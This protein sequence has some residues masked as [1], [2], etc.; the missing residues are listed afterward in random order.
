MSDSLVISVRLHEGWY[1]GAG[2]IP[3]P[4]RIFQALIAGRGLSGP[5]PANSIAALEWLEQQPPPIVAAPV[6]KAG[7]PVATFVPN[8]DLD[9]KQG[10]H[11]RIGEIRTKKSIRPLLFDA[12]VPFLFCWQ[13]DEENRSDSAVRDVCELTER[14]YQLGRTF[15]AAWAWA[16]VLTED[17]LNEHLRVHRG[18][19]NRPSVGRGS[20]ECP[21]PGSLAS[22]IRRHR[23]MSE[24]Y[25]LT[26]D[27]KGQTF[28]RRS[29]PKWRMVSYD[30]AAVRVCFDLIDRETSTLMSWPTTQTLTLVTA[31]RD[32]AV[33]K[34]AGSLPDRETEI[35]QTLIGRT[36]SGENTGSASA[37]VRIIPL[38]SIGHEKT[39]QEVRR[40]LV[41]IPGNCPLRTDDVAWAFSGQTL[42]INGRDVDLVCSQAHRQLEHYGVTSNASRQWQTVTPI[43]LTGAPRRRIEPDRTKRQKQ[44]LKGAGERRS[45]QEIASSAIRHALRHAG[46]GA[47]VLSIR[48]QR[49]PFTGRGHKATD[50]VVEPR[51]SKHALWH[52]SL[53]FEEP[54]G[55]PLCLGDG[56][57]MGLGLMRPI[58]MIEDVFAFSIE[59]GLDANP[60]PM[61]LARALR[62]AVMARTRDVLRTYRLPAYFTGHRDDGTPARSDDE[63]HLAFL[64]D[65]RENHLIVIA[66]ENLDRRPRRW[67]AENLATLESALE[68]FHELRAGADGHLRILPVS[69]DMNQHRL[70]ATSH[71]WQSV[72]PYQVNR[73][74]RRSTADATLRNDVLAECERRA[75]PRPEV[76]VLDWNALPNTGL[77]GRLRLTFKQAV[78]GP[79][80]L[81]R[82]RHLGGGVFSTVD[83]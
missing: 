77:R 24:R 40:I 56:R 17:E 64:F 11:R 55:G 21:T 59:S 66:P 57:F 35:K 13:L 62:R 60:D 51:F 34:L 2:S 80:V 68:D 72:T 38:P 5:L 19:I 48:V 29:K 46:I 4:A 30:S 75:L 58:R 32:N 10:D 6:T 81:G 20:V 43:A 71:V 3:S 45:E 53:E 74:S 50:F 70:F 8:N 15:D 14:V 76:T 79:I 44:D 41:E 9:A 25:G 65:P 78:K 1:H 42:G 33:A 23:E 52:A 18:T 49:E 47:K 82:T 31:I 12:D 63:P 16:E 67:N 26:A 37:R 39:S 7:Q 36:A 27:G 54:V 28:R 83:A 73:H 69:L 61:R 22:L